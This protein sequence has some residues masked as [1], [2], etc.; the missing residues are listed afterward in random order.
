MILGVI[1]FVASVLA[2]V[3]ARAVPVAVSQKS[4]PKI[5]DRLLN[6]LKVIEKDRQ[7]ALKKAIGNPTFK[8]D[9]RMV[10]LLSILSLTDSLFVEYRHYYEAMNT[11]IH[12]DAKSKA[13]HEAM[14]TIKRS[15]KR[16]VKLNE[17]IKMKGEKLNP[18]NI[19]M[20]GLT[21]FLQSLFEN[22]LEK[23]DE[24]EAELRAEFYS[25]PFTKNMKKMPQIPE[26]PEF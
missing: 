19:N 16:S 11:L 4:A 12:S 10:E 24:I 17:I 2:K 25:S 15:I 22:T 21:E 3:A 9:S 5:V 26:I 20:D 14:E 23:T 6:D 1:L 18:P 13:A 7:E 8:A